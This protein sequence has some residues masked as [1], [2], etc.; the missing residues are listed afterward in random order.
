MARRST[1]V[2]STFSMSTTNHRRN[3]VFVSTDAQPRQTSS[4]RKLNSGHNCGFRTRTHVPRERACARVAS[5]LL[6]QPG[7]TSICAIN[8]SMC[9]PVAITMLAA[10]AVFSRVVVTIMGTAGLL[11]L[12]I[13]SILAGGA[14]RKLLPSSF[15]TNLRTAFAIWSGRRHR[16]RYSRGFRWY[17]KRDG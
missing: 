1:L 2:D 8:R 6:L 16:R 14:L 10:A 9:F 13:E 11:S 3:F 7:T 17:F 12:I 4:R 5:P 15:R